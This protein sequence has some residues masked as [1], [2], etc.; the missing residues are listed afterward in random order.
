MSLTQDLGYHRVAQ[1]TDGIAFWHSYIMVTLL[2]F[3]TTFALV[4]AA[5]LAWRAILR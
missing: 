1:G 4:A 3:I 5:L 2:N